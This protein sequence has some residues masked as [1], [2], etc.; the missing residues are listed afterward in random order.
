MEKKSSVQDSLAYFPNELLDEMKTRV[1][2]FPEDHGI[3]LHHQALNELRD[4]HVKEFMRNKLMRNS[5][6]Q[7]RHLNAAH[8][9][10]NAL[11]LSQ[12]AHTGH[13]KENLHTIDNL[14][15]LRTHLEEDHGKSHKDTPFWG[16]EDAHFDEHG[17][18][19]RMAH[20]QNVGVEM[21][22]P[23]E[24]SDIYKHLIKDHGFGSKEDLHEHMSSI[25]GME[26]PDVS[27]FHHMEHHSEPY[28][29]EGIFTDPG[30]TGKD[31]RHP[32]GKWS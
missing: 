6:G 10:D 4:H 24:Q 21:P 13:A 20:S 23:A 14:D 28:G 5:A 22:H 16:L 18:G 15:K 12:A 25:A 30:Y 2:S 29:Q 26:E 31:H 32:R 9:I 11:E 3:N 8:A 19:E 27:E 1:A 7:E 17:G